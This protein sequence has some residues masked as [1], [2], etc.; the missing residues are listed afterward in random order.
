M[1]VSVLGCLKRCYSNAVCC[2]C[3]CAGEHLTEVELVEYLMTLMG[4]SDNPEVEGSYTEEP[5]AVLSELPTQVTAASF[6]EDLL[7]LTT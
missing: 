3:V 5:G 6:A 7:G 1:C 2:V 4:A